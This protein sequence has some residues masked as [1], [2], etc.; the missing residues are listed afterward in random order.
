M[1]FFD[2][3]DKRVKKER[4][5]G[6]VVIDIP[7]EMYYKE[8]ALYTASSLIENAISKCEFKTYE[9]GETVKKED[10]YL[11]NVSPNENENS[12]VFWHK[13]VRKMIRSPEGALVV[14]IRG[15]LHVAESYSV[16]EVRPIKGNL[17]EGVVLEG[18]LQLKKIFLSKEVF[19]FRL[20]DENV[21]LLIDGM[22]QEHGR[23]LRSAARTF[24]DTNGRKFK[25]KVGGMKQGNEEFNREFKDV[26]SKEIKSYM[27]NEYATY[28]EYDG[29]ELEEQ[30]E[31]QRTSS[32]DVIK[33]RKDVFDMVGQALKIPQALMT[34]N[35]T[36]VKDVLDV[37]LTLAVDPIADAITET[38]NKRATIWNYINGN[39]YR[40]DTGKIKHRD[41]FDLAPQI[42]KLIESAMFDVDEL[43]EELGRNELNEE[44][45]K[46]HWMTKNIARVEDVANG[47]LEG[48]EKHDEGT[49]NTVSV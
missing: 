13:V 31:R 38:L 47:M 2:F 29:E 6:T 35:V 34:G 30:T 15:K 11:L 48:G 22:Y 27:E 39:Y 16:K 23:L 28:V 25:F 9:N 3:L 43:R 12:S 1:G 24:R 20:E 44:W 8:L 49:E 7:P 21:R 37:F 40:V 14:E 10:Y 19:L 41:I 18:G 45:S 26:I 32:D 36:S 17:Y 4:Y 5:G 42:E 33:I 46:R